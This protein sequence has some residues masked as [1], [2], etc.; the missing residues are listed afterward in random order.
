MVHLLNY[1]AMHPKSTIR[2][3][4]SDMVLYIHIDTSFLTVPGAKSRAGSHF[5]LR[6][7]SED[8]NN[9]PRDPIPIND[10]IHIICKVL[11]TV[12]ASATEWR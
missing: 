11:W 5:Y 9:L 7:A 1:C 6:A 3:T 12:M 10:P 8:P 4:A 2:Y